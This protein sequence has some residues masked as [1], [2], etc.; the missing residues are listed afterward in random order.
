MKH[1]KTGT[2]LF[3][4]SLILG[5]A[6]ASVFLI[7]RSSPAQ[8]RA[9]IGQY[10]PM[11]P[12][13]YIALFAVL[14]VFF[15]PVPILV[16]AAGILF[17]IR[18]GTIYTLAGA[19]MNGVLMFYLSRFLLRDAAERFFGDK[20]G[21]SLKMSLRSTSQKNLGSVF[22]VLR[23]VPLVSYNLINYAA[24]ITRISLPIYLLT[25]A[26]GILPGAL[27]FLNAGDK[28]LDPGS[29]QFAAALFLLA[30]LTL[31]SSVILRI[32]LKRGEHGQHHHPDV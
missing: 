29:P 15:F 8:I 4:M 9:L 5:I 16:L 6:V 25:T 2:N 7:R 18:G 17:G 3:K 26:V 14:P 11:A 24:G 12:L 21:A 22:L 32:Y 31:L 27:V 20:L 1:Q 23:L 30:A 28:S 19:L 13:V 10:G